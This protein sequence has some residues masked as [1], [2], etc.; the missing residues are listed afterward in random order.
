MGSSLG[1]GVLIC[2]VQDDAVVV[3][4]GVVLRLLARH[5]LGEE[6]AA[7]VGARR[8]HGRLRSGRGGRW[9]RRW[10]A[11]AG[12]MKG[13]GLVVER[14]AEAWAAR[15]RVGG[16]RHLPE[17]DAAALRRGGAQAGLEVR[18]PVVGEVRVLVRRDIVRLRLSRRGGPHL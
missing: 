4:H 13:A 9:R 14:V 5:V 6:R 17:R 15:L 2:Q 3:E 18:R 1:E 8:G 7:R 11:D 10:S 12:G 16:Q